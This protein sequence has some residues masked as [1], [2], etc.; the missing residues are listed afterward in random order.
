M[1]EIGITLIPLATFWATFNSMLKAAELVN[2]IRDSVLTGVKDGIK[3]TEN[4]RK[5]MLY[6]W[7][8]VMFG[9]ISASL[10]FSVIIIWMGWFIHQQSD[11]LVIIGWVTGLTS[12]APLIDTVLFILCGKSDYRAMQTEIS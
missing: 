8:L 6:D 1:N 3:L 12:I 9:T 2:N 4:A 5:A 7:I 10:T 11:N